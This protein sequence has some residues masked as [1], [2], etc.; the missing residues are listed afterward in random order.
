MG[1]MQ[2]TRSRKLLRSY[3]KTTIRP[4]V[5]RR[6][7]GDVGSSCD[8]RDLKA[9]VERAGSART[10][11]PVRCYDQACAARERREEYRRGPSHFLKP[12][13]PRSS[14]RI[15]GLHAR[16]P[17]TRD[18]VLKTGRATIRELENE[19]QRIVIQAESGH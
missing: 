17:R 10:L 5:R 15:A 13:K 16:R 18:G 12:P 14:L 4:S 7:A 11:L 19:S 1:E 3:R 9:E 8:N 6:E 2:L